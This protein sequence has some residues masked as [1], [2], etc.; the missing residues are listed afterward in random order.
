MNTAALGA[1]SGVATLDAASK[2]TLSQI[3]S[4]LTGA[5]VYQGVWN[6][7][8]N[9]PALTSGTGTKGFYYKVSV[10][11]TTTLD[12]L[13]QWNPGDTVIFDG[14]TWDK[15]DGIANEVLSVANRTG[16]VVLSNTDISGLGT[17]ATQSTAPV[18]MGGLGLTAAVTGLLKGTG[19]AY[20][21][22]LA[23]TDYLGP[24][25][26]IDAGSF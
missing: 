12:T 17:L 7:S 19:S 18:G 11:G 4:S 1:A 20:A 14:A 16:V 26:I 9:T 22:A 8:T 3:P 2:L 10:A 15:I 13:N 23:D 6:A 5:V 21:V 25:T 24:N